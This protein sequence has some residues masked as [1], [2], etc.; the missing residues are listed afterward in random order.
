[1]YK[2]TIQVKANIKGYW[3][4]QND[5]HQCFW[6]VI[7]KMLFWTFVMCQVETSES[8]VG[9]FP[10]RLIKSGK[11]ILKTFNSLLI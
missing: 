9:I 5:R 1:M 11:N 10:A 7:V 4:N 8:L 3:E 2:Y 6:Y